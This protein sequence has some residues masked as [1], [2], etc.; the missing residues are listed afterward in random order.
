[1]AWAR[2]ATVNENFQPLAGVEVE[3]F[4]VDTLEVISVVESDLGGIALF[5][6]LPENQRYFFKVRARRTSTRVESTL[7]PS[8]GRTY[9][10]QVRL[11]IL[12]ASSFC[13]D[14][15]VDPAG[16]WG[17]SKTIQGAINAFATRILVFPGTYNE[18]LSVTDG[19]TLYIEGCSRVLVKPYRLGAAD[20]QSV[21]VTARYVAGTPPALTVNY[22]SANVTVRGVTFKA[23]AGQ[24]CISLINKSL[25]LLDCTVYP[26]DA[27]NTVGIYVEG[28]A[29]TEAQVELDRVVVCVPSGIAFQAGAP[30]T[31]VEYIRINRSCL[32]GR[33]LIGGASIH[34][35]RIIDTELQSPTLG[36]VSLQVGTAGTG[37]VIDSLRFMGNSFFYGG[38]QAN[39]IMSLAIAPATPPYGVTIIGNHFTDSSTTNVDTGLRIEAVCGAVSIIVVGNH[40]TRLSTPIDINVAATGVIV[41]AND[42]IGSGAITGTPT[43]IGG[44]E[45]AAIAHN[46]LSATHPDTLA[47][48]V[49]DGDLVIGNVTPKWSRLAISIPAANVRNV[50]GI[51]NGELRPSWKT[52]LDGTTPADIAA[53]GS[54]GTSLIFSH[55]D[56]VH[57]HPVFASGDLHTEYELVGTA[58]A[59]ILIHAGLPDI[60]HAGFIGLTIAGPAN[61]DPN[62]GDRITIEDTASVTW[63]SS[64]A[65]KIAATAVA[66]GVD[67]GGLAGLGDD[68]HTQYL[69][70]A[71]RAAAQQDIAKS[72]SVAT[73]ARIGSAAAPTNVT[74]GDLTVGRLNIGNEAFAQY[75]VVRVL[76]SQTVNAVMTG[77]YIRASNSPTA[78]GG[79]EFGALRVRGEYGGSFN[80]S[81]VVTAATFEF[82]VTGTGKPD[83]ISGIDVYGLRLATG[84]GA[85]M[86]VGQSRVIAGLMFTGA[87]RAPAETVTID[88]LSG[89]WVESGYANLIAGD[90]VT[91]AK[92]I[93]IENMG[94]AAVTNAYGISING[95]TGAVTTN[96]GIDIG[97]CDGLDIRSA[98]HSAFGGRVVIG[99][100]S[101]PSSTI[102][103]STHHTS[104]STA[105][106]FYELQSLMDANPSGAS[107][108]TYVG[109]RVFA[110]SLAG[111]AQN[112][113][114]YLIGLDAITQHAGS[115]TMAALWGVHIAP[116]VQL[117][118]G[119]LTTVYGA[120]IQPIVF[121]A[122]S[123]ARVTGEVRG[124]QIDGPALGAGPGVVANYYGI[125]L[126]NCIVATTLNVGIRVE[127]MNTACLWLSSDTASRNVIAWGSARDVNLYR[128]AANE[129]ATDDSLVVT[130]DLDVV[131]RALFGAAAATVAGRVV[132]IRQSTPAANE[133]E[134]WL[135]E[136]TPE[137]VRQVQWKDAL[138]LVAGDKVL[139]LV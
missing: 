35:L 27:A 45:L 136:G 116:Y 10:G 132:E 94:N 88:G 14:A 80:N 5:T 59:L 4:D 79:W 25:T 26:V 93:Y 62:A 76:D 53:A 57:K 70:L 114:G 39:T 122:S 115:G 43:P 85:P 98:G 120:Y 103:L 61:I 77:V 13:F 92:G 126:N 118:A 32:T 71:G 69:L 30:N 139:V 95:V 133:T 60:H 15:V 41:W 68:D 75:E 17:S 46:L 123:V 12:S 2:I 24:K 129:L 6:G 138:N 37:T 52:A 104:T 125:Y 78:S 127:G 134:L 54:A 87:G 110:Q 97:A 49:L 119:N 8:R 47:G 89:L 128:S 21:V 72:I 109:Q 16:Q 9:T 36:G 99:S 63:A 117:G 28:S 1:M 82:F 66:G 74:A 40:F 34:S 112:F 33:V 100:T 73:Y 121:L 56:H 113:T 105:G 22:G 86:S 18:A 20:S 58:A 131:R 29:S 38:G 64:G 106:S 50:L 124:L 44:G 11:Q 84:A 107:S 31:S 67:H 91:T 108:A 137:T 65:G 42:Y 83:Y 102:G 81:T 101:P 23:A 111:N 55:R 7:D 51:D 3:C 48:A 96:I 135:G 19:R 90:A 130:L